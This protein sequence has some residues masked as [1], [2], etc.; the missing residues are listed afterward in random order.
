MTPLMKA[1]VFCFCSEILPDTE[2]VHVSRTKQEGAVLISY[3][4]LLM[5]S[6]YHFFTNTCPIFQTM[7]LICIMFVSCTAGP[8]IILIRD[9]LHA[10]TSG[11][12]F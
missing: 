10:F 3:A 7:N 1:V 6:S 12:Q 2:G 5:R 9:V 11:I 4:L 8:D